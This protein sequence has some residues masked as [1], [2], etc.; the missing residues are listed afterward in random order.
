MAINQSLDA[1]LDS[2]M[3][4]EELVTESLKPVTNEP[5]DG[6][7]VQ[8][9]L[10]FE[11]YEPVAG[12]ASLVPKAKK[13][14][15]PLTKKEARMVAEP[16]ILPD[17]PVINAAPVA[18]TP[19]APKP[20][21]KPS[22][23]PI[24]A[25]EAAARV[26]RREQLIEQG[27]VNAAPSPTVAQVAEG[28]EV[29]PISTLAFDNEG[30]QATIRANSE[31][32][33][34]TDGSMSVRSIYMRMIN[35]GIP[36]KQAERILAGAPMESSVGDSELAKT[37]AGIVHLH[38]ESAKQIDVLMEKMAK[39]EL[40]YEG[41]LQL[42]Q[43]AA[44]HDLITRNLKGVSIDVGRTMNVFK[45]V[46][47]AGPGLKGIN[48][49][50][51]L[52][53]AGGEDA[54]LQLAK[55]YMDM[56]TQKAKNQLLEAGLG[57]KFRDAWIY[58]W[59]SNLL[60]DVAPHAFSFVSGVIQGA[61]APVE[62]AVAIP[63]GMTRTKLAEKFNRPYVNDRF[64]MGDIQARVSGFI[65]GIYDAFETLAKG[66]P[67]I[68][69]PG[70]GEKE[71]PLPFYKNY[72][73]G[74]AAKGDAPF[75]P[76][77]SEAFSDTPIRMFGK[78]VYRTPDITNTFLGKAIDTLGYMYSVP[79][80]SLKTAD[81]L[82]GLTVG[83]MQMNE[84]SWHIVQKEYDNLISSG[85][86][87]DDALKEA[88]RISASY[89]TERP[90]SMQANIESARKQVTMTEDFNRETALNEFYWKT[91]RI[92]NNTFIKPF[93]PFSKSI[94]N[95]FIE[96]A[97]RTP[98][99]NLIS[100]RFW[101]SWNK[102]GK[103]RD[104]A[105][106]RLA[107]GGTAGWTAWQLSTD[108]RITGAGPSDV[109]DKKALEALGWQKYSLTFG[110]G[111]LSPENIDKL[112][113]LTNVSPGKGPLEGYIFVN[114]ARFGPYSPVLAM[115]AD[116]GDAQKFY[117]G[118][119]DETEW[120]RLALAYSGANMEY[121]K[122]LPSAAAIGD[123]VSIL[124]TRNEDGGN[125]VVDVLTRVAKQYADVLYTGTPIL[126]STNATGL[127]H[128]ERLTDPEI[129]STRVDQMN[130]PEH[131]RFV[132]EQLNRVQSRLPGF[133]RSLPSE[134]DDIGN[135]KFVE[136]NMFESYANFLPFVQASKGKRSLFWESMA[137]I[138]HGPSKPRDI[139][140]GVRL[141]ATQY[142]RYKQL[143]GQDVK[144]EPSLFVETSVGA[145]MNLETAMPQ[146]LKDKEQYEI[147]NGRTFGVGDAQKFADNVIKKYRRIAKLR[148]IG[149]DP[150][151]ELGQEESPDLTEYGFISE[152]VE[153]PELKQE[154]EKSRKFYSVYGK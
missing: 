35:A 150:S 59:Q 33:L 19:A 113:K 146:L 51:V 53:N 142:N 101:D 68:N 25:D 44:F 105:M 54:L 123:L 100:P 8:Q 153:F 47:D 18:P 99:P 39:R 138:N 130:V 57:K 118:R 77:S 78:E 41:Q 128:I 82:V 140:D 16:K 32:A 27:N 37:V 72:G 55:D 139:W 38:D 133:S 144:I 13:L 22:I 115:G 69:V 50:Q 136:N 52:D 87:S 56:P 3:S 81:D 145:P 131:L 80:R 122:N 6:T 15:E 96:T 85:Y 73:V 9:N 45:R 106:A 127:A 46:Q 61:A 97:A 132:Y 75:A 1:R 63:I 31:A 58:V 86:S 62:R 98:G 94:T 116:I 95:E 152:S 24:P 151:P 137:S 48:I 12:V 112:S 103:D 111:E 125:K 92:F 7:P 134:L 143:Y 108:N 67:K 88:Q 148:M 10:S 49:R 14:I 89:L 5:T 154:I 149:F 102:G 60:T 70:L 147:D 2:A 90:M 104:L 64:F 23:A 109:Q 74:D 110:P 36:E 66:G 84:E 93:L 65:P 40:N 21:T 71:L 20:V 126:G 120:S 76:L 135:K 30:L 119:P 29:S 129:R 26:A 141:T 34:A 83:R 11:E 28:V 17:P 91:N 107:L 124:R 121:I 4:A 43:Q 42:R 79:F 117:D 114:H